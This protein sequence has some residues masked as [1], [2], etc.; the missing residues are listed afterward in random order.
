[1][2]KIL[3]FYFLKFEFK[4]LYGVLLPSLNEC[5]ACGITKC[6]NCLK[7]DVKCT[8]RRQNRCTQCIQF[9]NTL[10]FFMK[11]QQWTNGTIFA[12]FYM[13]FAGLVM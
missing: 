7:F 6:Y 12:T 11:I 10:I 13:M 4:R 8:E 9:F 1:M 3:P 2:A 5:A